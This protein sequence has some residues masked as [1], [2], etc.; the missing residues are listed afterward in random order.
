MILVVPF[1]TRFRWFIAFPCCFV[2]D[3][4]PKAI[5]GL[6]SSCMN[7]TMIRGTVKAYLISICVWSALSLLNG[8]QYLIFDQSVNIHSTLGQMILLAE[9]RGLSFALLTPPI[10]Y[11]VKAI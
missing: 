6:Q 1:D 4:C 9:G 11:I 5:A 10:F 7:R 2:P 8:W 3:F